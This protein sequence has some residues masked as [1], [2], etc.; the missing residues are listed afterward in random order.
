MANILKLGSQYDPPR[1]K[2]FFYLENSA[3]AKQYSASLLYSVR[4]EWRPLEL[5]SESNVLILDGPIADPGYTIIPAQKEKVKEVAAMI[6]Y[7][8]ENDVPGFK[9]KIKKIIL[10]YQYIEDLDLEMVDAL[11]MAL[12][13]KTKERFLANWDLQ[14]F[15]KIIKLAFSGEPCSSLD[16]FDERVNSIFD[17]QDL[18]ESIIRDV[19]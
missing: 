17:N 13:A 19:R 18:I 4:K 1:Y 9:T 3:I 2:I 8:I 6:K 15:A 11:E 16:A 12:K 14:I 10:F 7:T 5:Y